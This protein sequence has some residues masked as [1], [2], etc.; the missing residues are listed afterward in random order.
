MQQDDAEALVG[1]L[2]ARGD[3]I[4][5]DISDVGVSTPTTTELA[6]DKGAV[7]ETETNILI[8]T[9]TAADGAAVEYFVAAPS[10][11]EAA[12]LVGTGAYFA[13]SGVTNLMAAADRDC[14]EATSFNAIGGTETFTREDT[15]HYWQGSKS[16]KVVTTN[17]GDGGCKSSSFAVAGATDYICEV[18]VKPM[19]DRV[20]SKVVA[21]LVDDQSTVG[22]IVALTVTSD[23]VGKWIRLHNTLTTDA[24]AT[25]AVLWV[26]DS[27]SG[28]EGTFYVDG[29]QTHTGDEIKPWADASRTDDALAYPISLVSEMSGS[30]SLGGWWQVRHGQSA[31]D[32]IL[33]INDTAG[34]HGMILY[35]KSANNGAVSAIY[36]KDGSA[37]CPQLNGTFGSA[38]ATQFIMVVA[39]VPNQTFT[40]YSDGVQVDQETSVDFSYFDLSQTSDKIYVGQ[41]D[42]AGNDTNCRI[43]TLYFWPFVATTDMMV[44]MAADPQAATMPGLWASGDFVPESG[45]TVLGE[46]TGSDFVGVDRSGTWESN[47]VI[48]S[49]DL[50]EV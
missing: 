2:Q 35:S 29:A 41:S 43:S 25:T 50:I 28:D 4:G 17:A 49:F 8:E 20:G 18:Y 36:D 37:V 27:V 38:N 46:V 9:N 22:T 11:T 30:W 31:S 21:Y 47:N 19:S 23:H 13:H 26:T 1:I 14:E 12:A 39:D 6:S 24:A 42:T 33:E 44:S 40:M 7:P 15:D 10:T 3:R 16:V 5:F 45:V 48:V 34:A 32:R